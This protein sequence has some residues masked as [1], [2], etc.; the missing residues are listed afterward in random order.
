VLPTHLLNSRDFLEIWE[1]LLPTLY[2]LVATTIF[3]F[4]WNKRGETP[5]HWKEKNNVQLHKTWKQCSQRKE[6]IL[7]QWPDSSE[8]TLLSYFPYGRTSTISTSGTKILVYNAVKKSLLMHNFWWI[9]GLVY[10][11][12]MNLISLIPTKMPFKPS[13]K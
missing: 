11:A 3:K 4:F 2:I 12:H 1:L 6:P 8:S 9:V 13:R 7:S 5:L 10:K